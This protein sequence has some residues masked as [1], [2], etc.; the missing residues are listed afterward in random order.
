M[1]GRANDAGRIVI[2]C[3]PHQL[4]LAPQGAAYACA[5]GCRFASPAPGVIELLADVNTMTSDH[6]SLQWGPGVDFASF[7]R[8]KRSDLSAMTSRQ[9][10]WPKLIDRIRERAASESIR[11]F[12]AA[13]GYG[14]L[15]GDL[16]EAPAP[17]GLRYVGADIHGALAAIKRPAGAEPDRAIFVRWDVS[18][19]L[20]TDDRFDVIICRAAIHHTPDP[21]KTFASLA[22]RL[23]RGGTLAITAYAKK[24][25]MREASDDALRE[26]IV[27]MPADEALALAG[28]FTALGKDL[29]ASSGVIEISADLPFLQIKAGRYSIQQFIYDHFLKCWHNDNFGDRYSDIVNF[30]WYHPP[31]AYRY[32]VSE[33]REWFAEN[34]LDVV[35]VQTTA[36]QHYVEGLLR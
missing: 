10:G 25:P 3:P 16:F 1:A 21:R 12:D 14:G 18:E 29:Q 22:S 36:A 6:Y 34:G 19:P 13:C 4:P 26:R 31:Y 23:A 2:L 15:F 8:T 32:E 27:P 5:Q 20:P 9:M 7:Y 33:L 35:D 30:D 28:Q 11:L 24:A 17:A